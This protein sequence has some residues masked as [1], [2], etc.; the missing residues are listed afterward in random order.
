MER[1]I[2]TFEQKSEMFGKI[3]NLRDEVFKLKKKLKK[4]EEVVTLREG[5]LNKLRN[6]VSR[7]NEEIK[8]RMGELQEK[9]NEY[10]R[11]T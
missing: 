9:E 10:L 2:L 1:E 5:E 8:V 7:R 6:R 4:E 3:Y 11:L